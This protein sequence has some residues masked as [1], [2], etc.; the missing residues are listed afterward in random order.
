MD[1]YDNMFYS[2]SCYNCE[3]AKPNIDETNLVFFCQYHSLYSDIRVRNK[4]EFYKRRRNNEL[5]RNEYG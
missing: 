5:Q 2:H 1:N 4:C 3:F